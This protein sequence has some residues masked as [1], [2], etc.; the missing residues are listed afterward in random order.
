MLQD[1]ESCEIE[2]YFWKSLCIAIIVLY[3]IVKVAFLVTFFLFLKS[4]Y[5]KKSRDD[6]A[7]PMPSLGRY[8]HNP[9]SDVPNE[10]GNI[11]WS[12]I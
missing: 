6:T 10:N 2:K 11:P 3:L 7:I 9:N 1:L 8:T 5:V 12:V 4:K